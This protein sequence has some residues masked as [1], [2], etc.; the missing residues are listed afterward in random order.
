[1][2]TQNKSTMR[3][4]QSDGTRE[5]FVADQSDSTPI[6]P[7][8]LLRDRLAGR[9]V[10][11]SI[12]A[13]VVGILCATV[14]FYVAPVY[15][16]ATGYLQGTA[17]H[18]IIIEEIAETESRMFDLFLMGQVELLKS[19][20]VLR[21]AANSDKL[22]GIAE[23][24]GFYEFLGEMENGLI[25]TVPKDTQL[26]RVQFN[27]QDAEVA[28]L[29]TNAVMESYIALHGMDSEDSI[30]EKE[31]YIRQFKRENRA[32][33]ESKREQQQALVRN[34][35]YGTAELAPL[36][37]S[38]VEIMEELRKNHLQ[39]DEMISAMKEAARLEGRELSGKEI[40][41]PTNVQLDEF[42]PSLVALRK[43][44]EDALIVLNQISAK[45]TKEH[46]QYKSQESRINALEENLQA[47]TMEAAEKW[48]NGPGHEQSYEQL[49][50]RQSRLQDLMEST[51]EEI[52][53]M[54]ALRDRYDSLQREIVLIDEDFSN[55]DGRLQELQYEQPAIK[56]KVEIVEWATPPLQSETD[57]TIQL[58]AAS[59]VGGILVIFGAFFLLGSI[60]QKAF[61][62]RQLQADKGFYQSLGVVPNTSLNTSDSEALEAG[63]ACIHRLRNRIETLRH[64]GKRGFVILISSPFQG[65]GKTTVVT[66]MGWSYAEAGYR[67]CVVDADFI[68]R[69]LSHQFGKLE[70]PGLKEVIKGEKIEDVIQHVEGSELDLLPIGIDDSINPEH[71]PASALEPVLDEL[72]DIYDI[73]I[74]DT[75]PMSGSI[76]SIPIATT[77]DGVILTLRKGRSRLPL[78]RC[79]QDLRE[80][81]ANY[82][83]VIL[84]YA[85]KSDYR[86]LSSKSKSIDDLIKEEK[87]G[88]R[89]RNPLT[90]QI[91]SGTT[92]SQ[93][94][95]EG[96]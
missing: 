28:A 70:K 58:S 25:A 52:S 32:A 68:G 87:A 41:D 75:G 24:R 30:S 82:L 86:N 46:R 63:H 45:V 4:D 85:E 40:P 56:D 13:I 62:V 74:M 92:H 90:E 23:E 55:L 44:L 21:N 17:K 37:A 65:D 39:I 77:V 51:R 60:D 35:R 33:A 66:L 93:D 94:D 8:E 49:V 27:D 88:V 15:Y 26:I 54:N 50:E 57:K 59:F 42:E 9:W 18:E 31:G 38:N 14:S 6:N 19:R 16:R 48:K 96:S 10:I 76:E 79:V 7:L 34:S 78:R 67:T 22:K 95:T 73:I 11:A 3:E 43:D 64:H 1:M 84:N 72:R 69:T 71:A 29:A 36:I 91:V 2:N 89:E 80:L 12:L 61:G 53:E 47:R 81:G 83:G 20:N 5:Q